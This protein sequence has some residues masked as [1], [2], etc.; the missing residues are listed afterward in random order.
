[1]TRPM[2]KPGTPD[3]KAALR[4]LEW[5]YE[6]PEAELADLVGVE[7]YRAFCDG[8]SLGTE[9]LW[10]QAFDMALVVWR[11]GYAS[12]QACLQAETA[13]LLGG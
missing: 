13:R 4:I 8:N 6:D 9:D 5:A 3:A 2:P 11:K 10:R 7:A 1:M 12:Y